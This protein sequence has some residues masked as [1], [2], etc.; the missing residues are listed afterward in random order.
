M[1]EKASDIYSAGSATDDES[2]ALSINQLATGAR[3]ARR[4]VEGTRGRAI[5]SWTWS[6]TLSFCSDDDFGGIVGYEE[7]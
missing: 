1:I 5:F 4:K 7:D 2:N 3:D 6:S